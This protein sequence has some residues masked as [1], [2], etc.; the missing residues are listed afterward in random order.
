MNTFDVVIIGGG[1]GGAKAAGILA[2]GGKSVALVESTH[3]GGVCLNC[4]CIPTKLLLGA[5][6]PKGL[7]RGLGRQ[8]VAKGSIEVDYDALQKRIQ[9]FVKASSQTLSKGLEQLGVTLIEGRAACVSPSEVMVTGADGT[10]LNLRAEHII[11]AGGSRS[12]AFPGMTPDHD[13]VLDSTDM[14]RVPAVPESL[15]V[16]GA[17]AI[18]LEMA[19]FFN[20]M[21]SKVTIVE[22]APHLAPTEDADFGQEMAKLFGKT[23]ISC[24]TGVKAASLTTREGAAVLVLED[25]RELTAAKALV[26][27]GRTPNTDNLGAEEAGCTLQARGFITVDEHLMAAPNVYAIGDINGQTLLA[28]A[29]EHQGAYVARRIIGAQSGPYASGPVPSCVYGSLEIMRVGLTARQALAQCG[30]V[31]VSKAQLM[32]NAIAQAGGDASGFIKIVWQNDSIVG[33]AAL[34]HG[35]SHLVTAAQLLLIGQYHGSALNAF[36]FAHPTLDEAL[37]SA[38]E[39]PQEPCGEPFAG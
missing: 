34:G 31:A 4:G 25:G 38:L 36:M 32:G 21:G 19:D 33:I 7:L 15:I 5:T 9:R 8:R 28:H 23:G 16:V 27:V 39:A 26:A 6:A 30:P 24:I 17:G 10:V 22:A 18:G 12:A 37:H 2:R 13:A 1:P 20:A 3:M 11:L 29:A 35:V 14:L